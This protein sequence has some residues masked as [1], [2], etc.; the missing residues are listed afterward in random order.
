MSLDNTDTVPSE[1][2]TLSDQLA[3]LT[4]HSS[5]TGKGEAKNGDIKNAVLF[6]AKLLDHCDKSLLPQYGLF[7]SFTKKEAVDAA[8]DPRVFLNTNIPFSAFICGVQG[9]GKSHSTA[10]LIGG[11]CTYVTKS[12]IESNLSTENCLIRSPMLG[13]LQKPLSAL[14][15]HYGEATSRMN[16][17]PSEVAF[18][19]S[20]SPD[21]PN[22]PRVSKI[23][24]LVSPSNYLT[25]MPTYSQI[26]GV[27]VQPFKLLPQ[28]L[29]IGT[30][31]T[32]MSVDT[33]ESTPLYMSQ[34]TKILRE[35]AS[36]SK[37]GFDYLDFKHQLAVAKLDKK[38]I[39][40]LTQR[41]DLL[42]SFLDLKG[43]NPGPAFEAGTVT[44]MDLTCPFVD[45]NTACVL[46]KI[47][48]EMYLESTAMTGKLIAVDEAHKVTHCP[49]PNKPIDHTANK[50][51]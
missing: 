9:S 39:E 18:L 26:P 6:S 21:F 1:M 31:L 42:E 34:V 45:V 23:I 7:G 36:K 13:V 49:A 24:V 37:N 29:T 3:L 19:A 43:K 47:G 14:V 11:Y 2:P 32:L 38:Q 33:S 17:K 4:V 27:T 28:N 25:L 20:P 50:I 22:H 15:F 16:F 30:M 46:F 41:L 48:M 5:D 12:L 10:C 8:D 35:Q 51:T 40:F 44:I